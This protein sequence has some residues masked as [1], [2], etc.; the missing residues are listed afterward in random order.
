MPLS[1]HCLQKPPQPAHQTTV[2][3]LC[4][5]HHPRLPA[6]LWLT[7]TAKMKPSQHPI[8][9]V[10]RGTQQA[11][12][13]DSVASQERLCWMNGGGVGI[14]EVAQGSKS[15]FKRETIH[16]DAKKNVMDPGDSLLNKI[17]FIIE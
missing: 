11:T 15:N 6:S 5:L 1:L 12:A 8:P 14:E 7:V 16:A 3:H 9:Q 13:N 4:F 2:S 10:L 17:A